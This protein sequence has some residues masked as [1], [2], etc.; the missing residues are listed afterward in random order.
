MSEIPRVKRRS[1]RALFSRED[2][3]FTPWLEQHIDRLSEVLGLSLS[4]IERERETPTGFSIDLF[5]EDQDSGEEGVIECQLE[6]T[7]HDHL[8]KL[9]TYS[10]AY[11][12]ELVIWLVSDARYEHEKAIDWLNESTKK[13]FY[14]VQIEA[15]EVGDEV[16]LLFTP[17]A[18]PSPEVKG[19]GES[20]REPS[21]RNQKQE[22]FWTELL[23][24][25]SADFGLFDNISPKQ[26]G[27]ITKGSG[28]AGVRYCYRIRND[29]AD[30][31]FYIDTGDADLNFDVF[32]R[33]YD[34]REEIEAAIDYDVDWHRLEESRACRITIKFD[35]YGLNDEE[36]WPQLQDDMIDAMRQ[37]HSV[38]G[39][40]LQKLAI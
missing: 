3:E 33:L 30:A 13:L 20:K 26:Q 1:P 24:R 17:L 12:T 19:V 40:K 9:L 22:Q 28:V 27:Y 23:E 37:F 25:S 10:T 31:G 21:E 7:D 11:E 36:H 5:V 34:Q 8:G 18:T 15:I 39:R 29:W 4:I 6:S 38:F 32:D 16:S 35:A 14:L 2:T